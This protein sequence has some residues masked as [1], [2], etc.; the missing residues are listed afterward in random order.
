MLQTGHYRIVDYPFNAVAKQFVLTAY[1]CTADFVSKN[2]D[3]LARFRR[4]LAESV[5]YTNAHRAQMIP[6][7]A[8]YSGADEA[9]IAAMPP[10]TLAPPRQLDVALIQPLIDVA[11]KYKRID[12][13]FPAKELIDPAV[14]TG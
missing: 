6:V 10:L 4:A 13:G 8:K 14:L 9:S 7:I 3:A 12:H 11:V 5:T 1:F 2:A